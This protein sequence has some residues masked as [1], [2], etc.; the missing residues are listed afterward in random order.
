[1]EQL[2]AI[3]WMSLAVGLVIFAAVY[4]FLTKRI[5]NWLT[6]PGML[7]GIVANIIL[8]GWMIGLKES[9]LGVSVGFVLFFPIYFFQ[10]MGAGD[11]KLLMLIGA[12]VGYQ[13]CFYVALASIFIGGAYALVNVIAV[14]RIVPYLRAS[15]KFFRPIFIPGLV[16]EPLNLDKQRKFSFGF[17]LALAM[18]LVVYLKQSG[19]LL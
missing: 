1:M 19:K 16:R 2:G 12:F 8:S 9:L 5:P 18:I 15:Y 6:F 4:D 3:H 7:I 10:I 11:V 13:L 17:S 14:G